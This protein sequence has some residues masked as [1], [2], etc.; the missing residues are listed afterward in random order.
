[1]I[2]LLTKW[3]ARNRNYRQVYKELNSLTN[4]QLDDLGLTRGCIDQVARE[5]AYGK[6]AVHV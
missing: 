1:M 2:S 3:Y 4:H 6:A 5:S